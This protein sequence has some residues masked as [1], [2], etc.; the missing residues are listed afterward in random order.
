MVAS[1][2]L[3][4]LSWLLRVTLYSLEACRASN[5]CSAALPDTLM[6]IPDLGAY[7]EMRENTA[8]SFFRNINNNVKFQDGN[9]LEKVLF[10]VHFR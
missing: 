4:S 6:V 5:C 2:L 1:E 9:L 10:S 7:G 8:V 3:R